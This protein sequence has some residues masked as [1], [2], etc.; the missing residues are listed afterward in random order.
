MA[1][2]RC[3]HVLVPRFEP[4]DQTP[5]LKGG[6]IAKEGLFRAFPELFSTQTPVP[7]GE[8]TLSFVIDGR[9]VVDKT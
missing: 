7:S 8:S 5:A 6:V 4:V 2:L 3:F 1:S 9:S